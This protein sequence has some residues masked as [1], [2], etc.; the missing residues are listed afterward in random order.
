MD[1]DRHG[2]VTLAPMVEVN[3]VVALHCFCASPWWPRVR[4]RSSH[5]P[6]GQ[7]SHPENQADRGDRGDRRG[8]A[9]A[10]VLLPGPRGAR[11]GGKLCPP[12]FQ[13]GSPRGQQGELRI[14]VWD[15]SDEPNGP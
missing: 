12:T 15:L 7:S 3:V 11:G 13:H 10:E 14:K 9:P 2:M 4:P 8:Q 5:T 1:G 6:Q